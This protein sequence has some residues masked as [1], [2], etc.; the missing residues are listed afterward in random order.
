LAVSH[1]AA[2]AIAVL[3]FFSLDLLV[4]ALA[5]PLSDAV[6][7]LV[8]A[9]AIGGLPY[10]SPTPS[11]T[12]RIALIV[13]LFGLFEACINLAAAWLLSRWVYGVGPIAS[14]KRYGPEFARRNRV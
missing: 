8:T 11:F 7:F 6:D 9:I 1:I 12:D 13:T 2:V 14:L 5:Q 4:H 3:L 10:H